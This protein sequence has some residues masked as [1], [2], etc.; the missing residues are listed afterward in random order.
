VYELLTRFAVLAYKALIAALLVSVPLAIVGS[1]WSYN[2]V[3]C[4]PTQRLFAFGSEPSAL[5][6]SG[7]AT[8]AHHV[9]RGRVFSGGKMVDVTQV[10][11]SCQCPKE[12][13]LLLRLF[14]MHDDEPVGLPKSATV[15]SG[16]SDVLGK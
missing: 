10:L 2:L 12:D 13:K 14:G 6:C 5:Q 15:T 4:A 7:R 11:V 16:E 3:T 1:I 9:L 8:A